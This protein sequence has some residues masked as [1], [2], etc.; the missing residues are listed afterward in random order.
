M[1]YTHKLKSTS[2][3][4]SLTYGL[5]NP[6]LMSIQKIAL[7]CLLTLSLGTRFA[8]ADS[9][10]IGA[11]KPGVK[12][13]PMLYG[14]MTEEINYSYQGGLYAEL[15]QNRD[16]KDDHG[17]TTNHWSLVRGQGAS[18][19]MNLDATDPVNTVA[20]TTS[21]RLD[22]HAAGDGQRLGIANDGY[23]GIPV[24][25]NTTYRVSFYARA[26]T[27]FNGPITADIESADG[28]AIYAQAKIAGVTS[29]W[30]HFTS[31]L[32]TGDL[33]ASTNNR[34]VVSIAQPGTVWLSLVSLFPPT[35]HDR[36]NGT[37]IDL[38]E[39]MAAMHP[40]FLRFPGGNYLEGDNFSQH[41]DWKKTIG[42]IS[43]RPGHRSPWN[44]HS[45][46]GF[47]L[48]E[49]L[50]WCE[51]LKMAPVLAVFGGYT[52]NQDHVVAGPKLQPY[53]QDALDEIEYVTGDASTT[54]GARRAADGHPAP[55]ALKYVE[56]GNEDFFDH[57]GSYD[58]RFHQFYD[59]I[60]AKYPDLQ[61]IATNRVGGRKP[62]LY[63]EHFYPP[64][65]NM[66]RDSH[67]YDHY[68][69]GGP[70]VFVGEWASQHS[71][72]QGPTP[73]MAATLGDSAWMIGME[74]N[75]DLIPIQ[76]Y[77]PLLVNVNHGGKQWDINLIGYDALN[78]FGSPSYYAF[79]MF[80]ANHGDEVLP[81][82]MAK[83]GA[84]Q[85]APAPHGKMGVGSWNTQV[86]YKDIQVTTPG[87]G[88][89]YKSKFDSGSSDLTPGNG[90]WSV[91]DGALRQSRQEEDDYATVGSADW[92]DCTIQLKA[93]KLGG[94]EGF[95][96]RFHETDDSNYIHLNVGGW[97]N[98]SS[99]LEK[100]VGGS[101]TDLGRRVPGHIEDNRW[102]DIRIELQGQDIR[103]YVDDQLII[104]A[105][106]ELAPD[107]GLIATAS[108]DDASGDVIL[109]AVNPSGEARTLAISVQ[110]VPAITGGSGQ[111]LA[112]DLGDVDTLDEPEKV[113]PKVFSIQPTAQGL[114]QEFP[115]H[116]VTVLRLKTH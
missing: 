23:W 108:R 107:E 116:S 94:Q 70:K 73:A 76:C 80:S 96:I 90:A 17:P 54:W 44:Y 84:T 114:T 102:Y 112:G 51:D 71:P 20:L 53:V 109:K 97:Y 111:V 49:F 27:G 48:L 87:G 91:V 98:H 103:C 45:T 64:W 93:R 30:Q 18:G 37:R 40:A 72:P 82:T 5:H 67:H 26:A 39:K 110:G 95:L 3:C 83:D 10:T 69:R 56:I 24:K 75:S 9:I 8:I 59:A 92:T 35:F 55:F 78:S 104:E 74:R 46:D 38:M 100:A 7:G 28:G 6:A 19:E 2:G 63:D 89:L 34:F 36:P 115:P 60:K 52:L 25:P 101:K 99:G 1:A 65:G 14:L 16:F 11:D 12:I 88:V 15:I 66:L 13:S 62:D 42:D 79:C 77:A 29:Q 86:E 4:I 43:L 57:S 32:K 81:V 22:A 68:D 21:L 106:D 113:A 47:G 31:T 50:E 85:A 105:K 33:T 58:G 41:F 61:L